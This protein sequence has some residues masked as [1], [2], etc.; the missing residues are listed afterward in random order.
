M[1]LYSLEECA[2]FAKDNDSLLFNKYSNIIMSTIKVNGKDQT[3]TSEISISELLALNKVAQPDMVSIQ[4]N[5][6]FIN[7]DAYTSTIVNNGDEV[8]FLY[9]M[10]GG[11]DN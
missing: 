4:V 9:F 6:K 5:G 3:L 1:V 10:G 2:T 7:K 11:Q 8:D